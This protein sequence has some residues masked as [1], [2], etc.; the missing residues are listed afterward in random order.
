MALTFRQ[1]SLNPRG[2]ELPDLLLI[3]LAPSGT[4]LC[5]PSSHAVPYYLRSGLLIRRLPAALHHSLSAFGVSSLLLD[6]VF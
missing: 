3:G 6:D 2:T 1:A 4:F 5:G